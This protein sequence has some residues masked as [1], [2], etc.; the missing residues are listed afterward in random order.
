MLAVAVVAAVVG[1]AFAFIW[2]RWKLPGSFAASVA[3]LLYAPYEYLMHARVLC[4]GECNIRV[5]LLLLWPV[6]A[7]LTL[8]V[9]ARA[10]LAALRT[11]R[12]R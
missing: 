6:L 5:D 2:A 11:K 4:T 3:W 12:Q 1:A 8:A 10:L 7:V 9:P